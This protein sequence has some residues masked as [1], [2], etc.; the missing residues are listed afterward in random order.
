VADSGGYPN[1]PYGPNL[2]AMAYDSARDEVVALDSF[3]PGSRTWTWDGIAWTQRFPA[4]SP[5][6]T[7]RDVRGQMVF[8]AQRGRVVLFGG[9]SMAGLLD[10]TWTWDGSTWTQLAPVGGVHPS[11]RRGGAMTYIGGGRILLHGGLDAG[12]SNNVGLNDTWILDG[13]TWTQQTGPSTPSSP[14]ATG[15]LTYDA[16]AGRPV[17]VT[18]NSVGTVR[19]WTWDGDGLGW[20]D[21][22]PVHQPNLDH[23]WPRLCWDPLRLRTMLMGASSGVAVTWYFDGSD[24]S[25]ASPSGAPS[26]LGGDGHGDLI[27]VSSAD[28]MLYHGGSP[29]YTQTRTWRFVG[30]PVSSGTYVVGDSPRDLALAD[31]DGDGDLDFATAD[32]SDDGVTLRRNDGDGDFSAAVST[33]PLG[34]A[35]DGPV[36]IALGD[37]DGDGVDDDAAVACR[38]SRNVALV[39]NL[40]DLSPSILARPTNGRRP[41]HV[42]V[43]RLD[44]DTQDDIVVVCEGELIAGGSS[45][46]VSLDGDPFVSIGIAGATQLSKVAVVD[47]DGDGS[48]DVVA[49]A[50]GPMPRILLLLGDNTGGLS[51]PN[52]IPVAS[53]GTV[54]GLCVDDLDGDGDLDLAVVLSA[55][56][57]SPSQALHVFHYTPDAALDPT[58][59]MAVTPIAVSGSFAVDL[60]CG[61]FEDNSVPGASRRDFAV[62]CLGS[63]TALTLHDFDGSTFAST[64]TPAHGTSPIAVAIA[65]LNGDGVDDLLIANEGSDDVSVSLSV[66]PPLT[67]TYGTGC[68]GAG[69]L[70]PQIGALNDPVLDAT[71]F[72]VTLAQARSFAPSVL[73]FAF[74]DA[75]IDLGAGCTLL[76]LPPLTAIVRFANGSG[77]ATEPLYIPNDPVLVGFDAYFQ[78]AVFDPAGAFANALALSDGLRIQIGS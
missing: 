1:Y 63:G 27:Y 55:L 10:D 72:A 29:D 6:G 42:A 51:L 20:R 53:S 31:V 41:S 14:L 18:I 69:G 71:D 65:D 54:D 22:N 76:V 28:E 32:H 48:N 21:P 70:V 43:G 17:L 13:E 67:Q 75:A 61:D 3:N 7:G 44:G 2:A 38:D 35:H 68:P 78:W 50:Q 23:P 57:P 26:I 11:A 19:T 8:D 36:S 9:V 37:L 25:Q 64:D 34:V 16:A 40:P 58:D 24:W 60:A 52:V 39:S 47:L 73:L 49:L 12:S 56:F 30:E 4:T 46:E 15:G 77:S 5:T 33:L 62:A 59:Y 45:L 74:D 66:A